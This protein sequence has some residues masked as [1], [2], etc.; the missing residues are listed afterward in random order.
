MS[1]LL[2]F[3]ITKQVRSVVCTEISMVNWICRLTF[4]WLS[5]ATLTDVPVT[6]SSSKTPFCQASLSY[7][8]LAEASAPESSNAKVF[9]FPTLT[10]M[11]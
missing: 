11:V 3:S 5:N 8:A 2:N 4:S 1:G 10:I 7:S 6:G 9:I